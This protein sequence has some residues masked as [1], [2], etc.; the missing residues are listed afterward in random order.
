MADRQRPTVL[1]QVRPVALIRAV[2]RCAPRGDTR[3]LRLGLWLV[4][5]AAA[6]RAC[7]VA[8]VEV[9][10]WSPWL[11]LALS[12]L[13]VVWVVAHEVGHAVAIA[14]VGGGV[15]CMGLARRPELGLYFFT[16][17]VGVP[18][19]V[20]S[21]VR[22]LLAGYDA[23]LVLALALA[24]AAGVTAKDSPWY[25]TWH[26]AH[27]LA[28]LSLVAGLVP[29][30]RLT[31]LGRALALRPPGRRGHGSWL[32]PGLTVAWGLAVLVC[33]AWAATLLLHLRFT[34]V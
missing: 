24:L 17:V 19:D 2:A 12:P 28:M 34:W 29:R 15:P 7:H 9:P 21:Q 23:N 1:F 5:G 10:R 3:S 11:L 30:S 32:L 25:G 14:K 20:A 27:A 6:L 4:G 26:V 16:E 8:L 18:K 33:L 31:D 13:A 22:V